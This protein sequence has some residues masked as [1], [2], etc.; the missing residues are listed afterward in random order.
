MFNACVTW[1]EG[2]IRLSDA[3]HVLRGGLLVD[4]LGVL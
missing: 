1:Q 3:Q 2:R 4:V